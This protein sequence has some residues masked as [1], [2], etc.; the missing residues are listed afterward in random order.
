MVPDNILQGVRRLEI[1]IPPVKERSIAATW[2]ALI[3][4]LGSLSNLE[5]LVL[6]QSP[7][8]NHDSSNNDTAHLKSPRPITLP[9]LL[10]FANDDKCEHCRAVTASKPTSTQTAWTLEFDMWNSFDGG[11]ALFADTPE[12]ETEYQLVRTMAKTLERL[13]APENA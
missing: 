2:A 8:C 4:L 11:F 7:I 10:S 5:D 1:N 9:R 13:F 12:L 6:A 3:F